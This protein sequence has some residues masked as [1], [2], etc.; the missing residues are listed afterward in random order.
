MKKSNINMQRIIIFITVLFTGSFSNYSQAQ[1]NVSINIGAQPVW[2]PVG[3]D[4][5]E[6]YYIPD[7]DAYYD[8]PNR[9]YVYYD[10]SRWVTM[11]SLPPRYQ[12]ID[13]YNV[14]KVVINAPSPWTHHDQYRTQYSR[15][16]GHHDQ[17]AIRNSR[18]EK[19][20]ANPGHPHHA[21]WKG[22]NG[23]NRNKGYNGNRGNQ[24][25]GHQN[26]NRNAQ[27]QQPARQL[28][29]RNDNRG[30]SNGGGGQNVRGNGGGGHGKGNGKGNGKG[31]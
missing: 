30:R 17:Q 23:N 8:V 5:A 2:G 12:S 1:V 31:K 14:H 9:T 27:R 11:R 20:W 16:K 19:Y 29:Q 18:E 13:L 22:N 3:Y 7:I 28:Q 25:K 6:Y 21:K 10:N 26:K 4:Y 24:Y 15:Y